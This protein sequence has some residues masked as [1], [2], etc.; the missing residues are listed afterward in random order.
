M[1]KAE[2]IV[3]TPSPMP[4]MRDRER[5][6]RAQMPN[7][8]DPSPSFLDWMNAEERLLG[9]EYGWVESGKDFL[10]EGAELG[11]KCLFVL[12]CIAASWH[13]VFMPVGRKAVARARVECL[14]AAQH[15]KR[16]TTQHEKRT[17]VPDKEAL[18]NT[19]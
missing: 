14:E 6:L 13:F 7:P 3:A 18:N 2:I 4:A 10:R 11:A 16:T 8:S 19:H 17:T 5:E 1:N 9:A 15:E 12:G